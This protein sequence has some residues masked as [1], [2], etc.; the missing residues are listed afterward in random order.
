MKNSGARPNELLNLRWQDIQIKDVGRISQSKKQEEIEE[1]EAEGIDVV[2]E[3]EDLEA[4][5]WAVS[6]D[7]FS[8]E[9]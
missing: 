4:N 6:L 8:R 7:A 1:L 5:A 2:G 9:E 3:D